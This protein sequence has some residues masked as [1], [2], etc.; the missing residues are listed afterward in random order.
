M[1]KIFLIAG[2]IAAVGVGVYAATPPPNFNGTWTCMHGSQKIPGA[3]TQ[4]GTQVEGYCTYPNGKR[5]SF[6]GTIKGNTMSG[7]LQVDK[8]TQRTVTA[9]LTGDSMSGTWSAR[10]SAGGPWKATRGDSH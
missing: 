1:I 5:A 8:N 4:H 6:Q 9:T 2:L 7:T 3:L 10:G